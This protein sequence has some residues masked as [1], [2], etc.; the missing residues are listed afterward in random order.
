[1][2]APSSCKPRVKEINLQQQASTQL[3]DP[4]GVLGPNL[5][6][7]SIITGFCIVFTI[8]GYFL[9]MLGYFEVWW[10]MAC[11]V[12]I[13]GMISRKW[14][15]KYLEILADHNLTQTVAGFI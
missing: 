11:Q 5:G 4:A 13:N 1:M 7:I 9:L 8:W 2:E 10:P 6:L 14:S 15:D 12:V 3:C